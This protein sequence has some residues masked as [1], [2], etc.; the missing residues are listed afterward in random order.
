MVNEHSMMTRSQTKLPQSNKDKEPSCNDKNSSEMD[1]IRRTTLNTYLKAKKNLIKK[2]KV[3]NDTE[4]LIKSSQ[5]AKNAFQQL[6]LASKKSNKK[7]LDTEEDLTPLKDGIRRAFSKA[8]GIPIDKFTIKNKNSSYDDYDDY[9]DYEDYNEEYLMKLKPKERKRLRKLEKEVD[10][11]NNEKPPNKYKILDMPNLDMKTKALLVSKN[12]S[13]EMMEEG[14]GEYYKIKEWLDALIR[15]PFGKYYEMPVKFPS[16][17]DSPKNIEIANNKISS[18]MFDIQKH[19]NAAVYG[20]DEAKN[21][22]L[23][24]IGQWITNP[25]AVPQVIALQGPPGNGKTSLAKDGIAK[26]LGRPFRMISLGGATDASYLDGHGFTYEGSV[27][28]RVV[29]ILQETRCMNP[30]IFFDEL[31]KVSDSSKGQEIIGALTHLTDHSQNHEWHD[32]YFSGIDFDLSKALLIFSFNDEESLHPV[33]K[34]RIRI[35][36]TKG[37]DLKSKLIIAKD[38]MIPKIMENIKMNKEHVIFDDNV[39]EHIISIY[40]HEEKG[41]R[42]LKQCI[43][44]IIMKINIINLVNKGNLD[45]EKPN[46][47]FNIKDFKLPIKITNEIADNL[48]KDMKDNSNQPP[49]HMYI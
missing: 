41:V 19:L 20:H 6:K 8:L 13:L 4:S 32:R 35:V 34:D 23:E 44:S 12:E 45:K 25:D 39:I 28:G 15:V 31:D 30:V 47:K 26:A 42:K 5:T 7:I 1:V 49:P 11:I 10:K 24:L 2:K 27:P 9:D 14:N 17:D 29:S 40:A 38:Y 43:E 3:E 33:L 21:V 37:H 36:R 16:E 46:I 22:I 48:I 18:Y